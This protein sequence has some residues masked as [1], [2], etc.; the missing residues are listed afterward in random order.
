[1]TFLLTSPASTSAGSAAHCVAT[2]NTLKAS[3]LQLGSTTPTVCPGSTR[4][5]RA[6]NLRQPLRALGHRNF[7]LFFLGQSVSLIGTWVQQL[8]MS[9]LVFEL[10]DRSTFWLG[11][12]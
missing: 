9:W 3:G 12:I 7:R 5:S 1:M 6:M 2:G 4:R 10:T 8:A 11:L